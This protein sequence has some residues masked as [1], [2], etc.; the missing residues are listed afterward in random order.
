MKKIITSLMLIAAFF[1][2]SAAFAQTKT[3]VTVKTDTSGYAKFRADAHKQIE[4]NEKRIA[5]LKAKKREG[6]QEVDEKYNKRVAELEQKNNDLKTRMN[7][8]NANDKNQKWDAFKREF[9]HDMKELG[10]ALKDV[11]KDNVK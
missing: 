9:N 2:C 8:Y 11:G 1:G 3:E 5:E 4:E 6:K 10:Q 7:N